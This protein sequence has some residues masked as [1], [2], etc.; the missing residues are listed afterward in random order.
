MHPAKRRKLDQPQPF[1]NKPFR[2]PLR[3]VSKAHLQQTRGQSQDLGTSIGVIPQ[4]TPLLNNTDCLNSSTDSHESIST[5]HVGSACVKPADLQK[6]CTALSIRL[7]QLRQSLEKADQ[8]LH[9][10]E[11]GQGTELKKLIVKWRAVAQEAAD[12]LFADARERIE[13]M[14]G[15]DAWRRQA[16]QDSRHWNFDEKE[17]LPQKHKQLASDSASTE[18]CLAIDENRLSEP[19]GDDDNSFTMDTMLHQMNIDLQA[20]GFDKHLEKWMD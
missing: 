9:I 2:S 3:A 13:G 16:D 19:E 14:G 15:V 11:S 17:L 1:Q 20:I 6:Q 18:D 10:E 12:E 7:S 4:L 8:A 5:L